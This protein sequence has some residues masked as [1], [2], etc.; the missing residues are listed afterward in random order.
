MSRKSDN[1]FFLIVDEK[2]I[3]RHMGDFDEGEKPLER[4]IKRLIKNK[5]EEAE[6]QDPFNCF[7]VVDY[8]EKEKENYLDKDFN[9]FKES[10]GGVKNGKKGILTNIY[11]FNNLTI[12][13]ILQF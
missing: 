6:K 10:N 1:E 4:K 3:I 8:K 7:K 11:N 5:K 9:C 13:I 2:G 12:L